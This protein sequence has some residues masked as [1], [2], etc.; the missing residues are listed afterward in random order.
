[1]ARVGDT[2]HG[3]CSHGFPCCPHHVTGTIVEGSGDTNGNSSEVARDGDNVVHNCPHCGTGYVVASATA[4]N[5]NG[6]KVARIGDTVIYPG[7][8]GVVDSAS[9]NIDVE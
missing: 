4:T 8:S 5:V 9:N 6:K 7:G 1:M 2:H 3:T